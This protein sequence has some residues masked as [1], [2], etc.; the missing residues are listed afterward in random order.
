M[1]ATNTKAATIIGIIGQFAPQILA[2]TKFAPIA[3]S[4]SS[5]MQTAQAF[6]AQPGETQDDLNARRLAAVLAEAQTA[7]TAVNDQAGKTLIDPTEVGTVGAG[8]IGQV[9]AAVNLVHDVHTAAD[10]GNPVATPVPVSQTT[11]DAIASGQGATQ[12]GSSP[13]SGS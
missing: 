11:V 6:L 10:T 4:V 12:T 8:I 9:K 5:A 3:S 2:F 1:T 13:A 7:A